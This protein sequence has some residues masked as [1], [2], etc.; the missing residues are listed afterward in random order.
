MFFYFISQI[1]YIELSELKHLSS[2]H[3]KSNAKSLV[4]ASENDDSKI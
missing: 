1:D 3:K 2:L 4:S